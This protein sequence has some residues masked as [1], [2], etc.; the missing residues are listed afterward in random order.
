MSLLFP[1]YAVWCPYYFFISSF[2]CPKSSP[3][4]LWFPGPILSY[5]FPM[6]LLFIYVL[7]SFLFFKLLS[8]YYLLPYSFPLSFPYWFL[9]IPYWFPII[10]SRFFPIMSLLFPHYVPFICLVFRSLTFPIISLLFSFWLPA[11]FLLFP[12]DFRVFIIFPQ[13]PHYFPIS[14]LVFPYF[15]LLFPYSVSIAF[16]VVSL[17]PYCLPMISIWIPHYFLIISLLFL[18]CFHTNYFRIISNCSWLFPEDVFIISLWH[19]ELCPLIFHPKFF[20][21]WSRKSTESGTWIRSSSCISTCGTPAV[22]M[23]ASTPQGLQT[24]IPLVPRIAVGEA[25]QKQKNH[26]ISIG[27]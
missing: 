22:W 14:S 3:F 24:W 27:S 5:G 12:Y 10:L 23:K 18:Y 11:L 6:S 19:P 25:A 15:S 4:F 1:Y 8:P 26:S 9:I 20:S 17:C 21:F 7:S 16:P 13:F 2:V